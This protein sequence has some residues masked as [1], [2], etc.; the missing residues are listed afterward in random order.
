MK[1]LLWSSCITSFTKIGELA[2]RLEWS[3]TTTYLPGS[4][5]SRKEPLDSNFMSKWSI[6]PE[7]LCHVLVVFR[8]VIFCVFQASEKKKKDSACFSGWRGRSR[9]GKGKRGRRERGLGRERNLPFLRTFPPPLPI[10]YVCTAS[11]ADVLLACHAIL[12]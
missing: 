11:H 4:G 3:W 5:A 10:F 2:R 12:P 7:M 9:K 1:Y 6:L 8:G